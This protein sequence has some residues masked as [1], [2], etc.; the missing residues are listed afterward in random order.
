[1][2]VE[3]KTERINKRNVI[4]L[5]NNMNKLKHNLSAVSIDILYF[6]IANIR[7]EDEE[8]D[9]YEITIKELETSLKRKLNKV[10]LNNAL[11][12]LYE[13]EV[14][15][16]D[17]PFDTFRLFQTCIYD[18]ANSIIVIK[19]SEKLKEYLLNLSNKFFKVNFDSLLKLKSRYS[20]LLYMQLCQYKN[21]KKVQ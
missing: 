6:I 20:K 3:V 19:L 1:M 18:S 13:D 15:F 21:M 17:E 10:S 16:L 11:K 14:Y 2:N 8:F 9:I 12:E 7:R 5:A 4:R